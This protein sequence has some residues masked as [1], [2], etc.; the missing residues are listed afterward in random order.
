MSRPRTASTNTAQKRRRLVNRVG[1]SSVGRRCEPLM[2]C[3]SRV[4]AVLYMYGYIYAS[5]ACL[6]RIIHPFQAPDELL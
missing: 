2:P 5:V 6:R 4:V 1:R 3:G